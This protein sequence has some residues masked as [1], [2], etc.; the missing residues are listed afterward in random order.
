MSDS[1][2]TSPGR[3]GPVILI[4]AHRRQVAEGIAFTFGFEKPRWRFVNSARQLYGL[5]RDRIVPVLLAPGWR[6]LPA[7]EVGEIWW[8][9]RARSARDP[10]SGGCGFEV[11]GLTRPD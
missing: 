10:R 2:A 8:T 5:A 11:W 6:E 4:V 9:L 7:N 3:A 1:P